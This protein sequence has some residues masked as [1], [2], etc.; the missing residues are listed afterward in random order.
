VWPTQR[1]RYVQGYLTCLDD[2][3]KRTHGEAD[4]GSFTY[5][6]PAKGYIEGLENRLQETEG[7]LLQILPAVPT[8]YLAAVTAGGTA[9]AELANDAY[10]F[11]KGRHDSTGSSRYLNNKT[12]VD[13]WHQFPL[14][15]VDNIRRWQQD[16]AEGK[17]SQ[18]SA[19]SFR[20]YHPPAEPEGEASGRPRHDSSNHS[21][22]SDIN[23]ALRSDRPLTLNTGTGGT[24]SSQ[25][26]H[27]GSW[28]QPTVDTTAKASRQ[29]A[30]KLEPLQKPLD[31]PSGPSAT[32][33]NFYSSDF[34][35]QFF[36]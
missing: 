34:Q 11:G 27:A 32:T 21:L 5:R 8:D 31:P 17:P 12:G 9:N 4:G 16:C 18:Q 29:P 6:G 28:S 26:A 25:D 15:S 36:W 10:M 23:P 24:S 13:Y 35:R 1:K 22:D 33:Q 2:R 7:L 14:N 30:Q 20:D 19:R 3:R